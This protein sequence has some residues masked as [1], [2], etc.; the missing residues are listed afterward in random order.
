MTIT[1]TTKGFEISFPF[2]SAFLNAV[3]GIGATWRP[4]E[5]LWFTPKENFHAVDRIAKKFN[6]TVIAERLEEYDVI[7]EL[8]A[9]TVTIPLLRTLFPYQG[10]GVQYSLTHK[11]VIVG[12]QPGLGKT[13]QAIATVVASGSYPCLIICPSTLKI[14]WEKE[15]MIVAGEKCLI[16]SDRTRNTWHQYWKVGMVKVFIVNYESLKKYF[17]ESITIPEDE[18]LKLKYIKFREN[19]QLFNSVIIDE[20]HK[21]KEATTQQSKFVAGICMGKAYVLGL[22]GTPVVNKPKDLIAQLGIIGMLKH[23]GGQKGFMDRYCGGDGKGAFNLK[24]L[25]Y[26]LC[27]TC[28]YQRQKKDVLK[29]LPD[30]IRKITYCE[31]TNR[32]EYAEVEKSLEEYLIKWKNKT[33]A[34]VEKSLRGE[35]MVLMGI[36]KN[37]SARGKLNEVFEYVDEITEAGEKVVLFVH[38]K[39][40]AI[41]L[42]NKY[43]QAVSVRGDDSMEQRDINVGKFQN[44]PRTNVIICSI[45]AAGVGITLTA[46]SRVGMVELPWHAAHCDQCEDRCHR[47]GQKGSVEATYFLGKDTIDEDIYEIIEKKRAIANDVTGVVDN[48]QRMIIDKMAGRLTNKK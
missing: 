30:K 14:N 43:K 27:M 1:P 41:A 42:L 44:D 47:I 33:D 46:S 34:E 17:V 20:I 11:R 35:I 29:D 8:P 21:C 3:K 32:K 31:I 37:I 26:K 4:V 15:W 40:I 6:A 24:E 39:E 38:Q 12:D 36:Q 19:V 2:N 25:N 48:I 9:L 10:Q 7:P 5:K 18:T 23:F 22:T 45:Q 13:S 16:L 28:F